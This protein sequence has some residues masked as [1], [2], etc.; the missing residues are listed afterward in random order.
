M[1]GPRK[2]D[3]SQEGAQFWSFPP[4][5]ILVLPTPTSL[6]MPRVIVGDGFAAAAAQLCKIA[7]EWQSGEGMPPVGRTMRS[8]PGPLEIIGILRKAFKHFFQFSDRNQKY[9]SKAL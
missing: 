2:A 5:P 6:P 7:Y 4:P 3:Q 8:V 9:C 1:S